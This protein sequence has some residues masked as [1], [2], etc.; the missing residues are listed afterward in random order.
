MEHNEY[1][2]ARLKEVDEF[3]RIVRQEGAASFQNVL[4]ESWFTEIREGIIKVSQETDEEYNCRYLPYRWLCEDGYWNCINPS[5]YKLEGKTKKKARLRN[6]FDRLVNYDWMTAESAALEISAM[7]KFVHDDIFREIEPHL[8]PNTNKRADILISIDKRDILVELTLFHKGL[9]NPKTRVGTKSISK[10]MFKIA[11][12][13][14]TKAENQLTLAFQPTLLIIAL[15]PHG[16]DQYSAK[17]AIDECLSC[18]PKVSAIIVSDSY[19]FKYGA[20]YFND[21]P[22]A[23]LTCSEKEY[24]S[25]V[26]SLNTNIASM[27]NAKS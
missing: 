1:C 12:K 23:L 14:Q 10:M 27:L 20:W 17:W 15:H 11:E 19:R 13:I 25:Q 21:N 2:I 3:H 26:L 18:F 6:I 4:T 22:Y 7:C 8:H 9:I 16:S 5:V 24:L